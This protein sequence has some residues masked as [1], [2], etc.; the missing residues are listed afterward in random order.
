MSKIPNQPGVGQAP[1]QWAPLCCKEA[2][3][4]VVTPSHLTFFRAARAFGACDYTHIHIGTLSCF[5]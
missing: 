3:V 4:V 1:G 2:S 5:K